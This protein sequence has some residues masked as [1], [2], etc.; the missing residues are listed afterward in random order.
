M[1]FLDLEKKLP[2]VI[3]AIACGVNLYSWAAN[4]REFIESHI[5][6]YG[7][8][9]FRNFHIENSSDLETLIRV[10]C[11]ETL[12]YRER[13]SPRSVIAGKIYTS[14]EHPANQSISMHCENSYQQSWPMRIFFHCLTPATVG[15]ETPIADTRKV[16]NRIRPQLC[17][18]FI[19]K[20]VMYV[21]NFYEFFGLPWQTVFQTTNKADV[22]TY[23]QENGIAV[24][25]QADG[26]L[27]TRAVREPV[28][29]HPKTGE[30]TWFNHMMFYHMSALDREIQVGLLSLFK[31][32][33]LPNNS[34]YGDG[35]PIEDSVIE[36]IK[37]CYQEEMVLV[38]WQ[39]GDVLMLDNMLVAHGR[40]PYSG[41]RLIQVGMAQLWRG[42]LGGSD[43]KQDF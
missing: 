5:L 34:F 14:T 11:G 42:T 20:K 24:E 29:K 31:P 7:G 15:G 37:Q 35:T 19:E 4:N 30:W 9:L 41:P 16:L 33:E 23:C 38:A 36:E 28:L 17:Q 6:Q 8:L 40:K 43:D 32:D 2:L 13:S 21:R 3:E 10:V 39:K 1:F 26:Y 27:K 12:E 18:Q 25:W 22:E